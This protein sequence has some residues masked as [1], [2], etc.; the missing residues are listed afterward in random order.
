M[1]LNETTINDK[2]EYAYNEFNPLNGLHHA[3]NY[4]NT[5]KI[6]NNYRYSNQSSRSTFVNLVYNWYK[7]KM[8]SNHS[9]INRSRNYKPYDFL[10]VYSNRFK[11][12][13]IY[14][15]YAILTSTE[16]D[17]IKDRRI[18]TYRSSKEISQISN[19]KRNNANQAN[20]RIDKYKQ[21]I[22]GLKERTN[23]NKNIIKQKHDQYVK[24]NKQ[25]TVD[26]G[27]SLTNKNFAVGRLLNE[28]SNQPTK[29]QACRTLL[30][31][32]YK[33]SGWMSKKNSPAYDACKTTFGAH[34]KKPNPNQSQGGKKPVKKPTTKKPVKKPTTKKPV[35]KTTTKKPTT[36]KP[37]KKTTTKK[38][39]KKPTT[40]KPVKK[41]TTKKP[42]KKTTTKKPVKKTTTKKPIKK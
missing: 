42:V 22:N 18:N 19:Q 25:T 37:V 20:Q 33:I 14:Y 23:W 7:K 24:N 17:A 15:D 3:D 38:P 39:V 10:N 27:R 21:F 2:L 34:A 4:F 8:E 1:S 36:K 9:H 35:K 5:K 29:K 32:S 11:Q 28:K 13:N 30:G 41:T 31:N 40:K 12:G 6:F 26:H 16:W